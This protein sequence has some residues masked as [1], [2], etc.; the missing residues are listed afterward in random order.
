MSHKKE[1]QIYLFL[2]K[3]FI[4][5]K[6]GLVHYKATVALHTQTYFWGKLPHRHTYK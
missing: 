3:I 6:F 1:V 4:K 5:L 2:N